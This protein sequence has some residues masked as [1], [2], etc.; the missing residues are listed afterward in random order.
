M[1][2]FHLIFC[3]PNTKRNEIEIPFTLTDKDISWRWLKNLHEAIYV[4]GQVAANNRWSGFETNADTPEKI[5][6]RMNYHI[7]I[8]RKYYPELYNFEANP[9]MTQDHFNWLHTFFEKY[10]GELLEPH[11][12]YANGTQEYKDSVEMLNIEIHLLENLPKKI[13]RANFNFKTGVMERILPSDYPEFELNRTPNTLYLQYN[14][15]GKTLY[16]IFVDDDY[17]IGDDHIKRAE[18][19]GA[20]FSLTVFGWTDE[21]RQKT[22]A[23]VKSW[24]DRRRNFLSSLGFEEGDPANTFGFVP[25]ARTNE[26][27]NSLLEPRQFLKGARFW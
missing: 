16:D 10:R 24:W 1:A 6:N 15:R 2:D 4:R 17:H 20:D 21:F 13:K 18:W 25:L 9:D 14:M 12:L 22:I 8:C 19:M 23:D 26:D 27:L 7:G 3:D 11:P 5:C